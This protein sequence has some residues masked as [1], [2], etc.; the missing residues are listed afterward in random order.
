MMVK[1]DLSFRR[2]SE[3]SSMTANRDEKDDEIAYITSDSSNDSNYENV[4]HAN[5]THL[6]DD[7]LESSFQK[8]I[9][10]TK[11][12]SHNRFSSNSANIGL[13]NPTIQGNSEYVQPKFNRYQWEAAVNTFPII[14]LSGYTKSNPTNVSFFNNDGTFFTLMIALLPILFAFLF[15]GLGSLM[16]LDDIP[17]I[18]PFLGKYRI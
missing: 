9:L 7:K 16:D 8:V 12:K 17:F 14:P 4:N 11:Q 15:L 1:E 18:L 3:F 13:E 2:R 10:D 5:S 6:A